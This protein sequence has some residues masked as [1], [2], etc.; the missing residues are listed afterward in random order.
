[1]KGKPVGKHGSENAH[2]LEERAVRD[3]ILRQ[4]DGRN[5]HGHN[6]RA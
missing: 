5:L 3:A 2:D 1:M 4:Y 6:V